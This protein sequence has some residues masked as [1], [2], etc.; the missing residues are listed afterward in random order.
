A[1]M[2]GIWVHNDGREVP[3]TFLTAADY[4]SKF[5]LTVQSSQ[6]NEKGLRTL[7]RG[8]KATMYCGADWEG[9][10]YDNLRVVPEPPYKDEFVSK[11]GK[12]EVIVP[13]IKDEGDG[14]HI[15]NFFDC[16]RSRKAPNCNADLAFK[17]MTTIDLSVRSYREGKVFYYDPVKND[18]YSN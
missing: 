11:W 17:V 2:G 9:E 8:E 14:K 18:V 13:N 4:P 10:S 7:I 15:D 16:V 1:G 3:D 12:E 5:S 6:A